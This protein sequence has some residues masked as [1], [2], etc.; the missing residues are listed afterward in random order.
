MDVFSKDERYNQTGLKIDDEATVAIRPIFERWTAAGV[1]IRE[2][3]HILAGAVFT[4]E[5]SQV[6]EQ[7]EKRIRSETK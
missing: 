3:S 7:D 4:E 6:L 1:S 5:C 2:I